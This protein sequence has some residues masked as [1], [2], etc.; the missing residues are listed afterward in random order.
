[1]LDRIQEILDEIN[2]KLVSD[3]EEKIDFINLGGCGIFALL[4]WK[5]LLEIGIDP[6][7]IR[8]RA[9]YDTYNK[10]NS[11]PD[12]FNRF[13][14]NSIK[15]QER[16]ENTADNSWGHILV[17]LIIDKH[18]SYL[19]DGEG[20]YPIKDIKDGMRLENEICNC[21]EISSTFSMEELQQ[22]IDLNS[23]LIKLDPKHYRP[24]IFNTLYDWSQN[25]KLEKILKKDLV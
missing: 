25:S 19:I 23:K 14:S 16:D 18:L 3:I 6:S 9:L 22:L 24:Y 2:Q 21:D 10:Y 5:R 13:L 12:E 4:L 15:N 11:L 7:L 20:I 8:G 1:M 17:E